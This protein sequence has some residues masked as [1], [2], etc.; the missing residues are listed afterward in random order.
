MMINNWFKAGLASSLLILSPQT[1]FSQT[2]FAREEFFIWGFDQLALVE[3]SSPKPQTR[4][5][6]PRGTLSNI[7]S[8]SR[9][10]ELLSAVAYKSA[11][12]R[13]GDLSLVL[14]EVQNAT[15]K[16]S[17]QIQGLLRA[18]LSPTGDRVAITICGNEG[19]DLVV[20]NLS[21]DQ[22]E[23]VA[24]REVARNG[25]ATWHPSGKQLA[26]E[27]A[28]GMT[29]VAS[30]SDSTRVRVEGSA[31]SWSPTGALALI[32]GKTIV[33]YDAGKGTSIA[34]LSR[35]FWQTPFTGPLSW[36]ADGTGF[37]VNAAAG[38]SG[39]ERDCFEVTL[40]DG[41]LKNFYSGSLTCGPWH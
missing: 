33:I 40:R 31:P 30:L 25:S 36:R 34:L 1:I 21:N 6:V 35:H 14:I 7:V 10:Q 32:R 19:C 38:F 29:V 11:D 27:A 37:L 28:D 8:V 4:E 9:S 39:Y 16:S 13:S 15:I 23:V 2:A 41:S 12:T 20:L 22:R 17:R 18:S 26:Y 24:A 5:F 3:A